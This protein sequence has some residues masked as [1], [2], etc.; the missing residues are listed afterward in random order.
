MRLT[1]DQA[2][3]AA[4]RLKAQIIK[5]RRW[6]PKAPEHCLPHGWQLYGVQQIDFFPCTLKNFARVFRE[7]AVRSDECAFG[8]AFEREQGAVKC[9]TGRFNLDAM[10]AAIAEI[11]EA[12]RIAKE[13]RDRKIARH[14]QHNS[15]QTAVRCPVCNPHGHTF[16]R[17]L[18]ILDEGGD[19]SK[20]R[21]DLRLQVLGVSGRND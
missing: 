19:P 7:H 18:E 1:W 5:V 9:G 13:I 15:M 17:Y 16:D 6:G 20:R 8:V 21:S 3:E 10:E 12:F 4:R 11:T 14:K 2:R